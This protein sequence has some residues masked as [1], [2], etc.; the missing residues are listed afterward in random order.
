MR[1]TIP[2]LVLVIVYIIVNTNVN[3][4]P[5]TASSYSMPYWTTGASMPKRIFEIS[6]TVL[7]EKIYVAGGTDENGDLQNSLLYYDPGKDKW[8][9]LASTPIAL[10]HSALAASDGKLILVG[11]W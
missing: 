11:M 4:A 9:A 8:G 7:N 3:A 6:A 1:L 5:L 10:D 2:I